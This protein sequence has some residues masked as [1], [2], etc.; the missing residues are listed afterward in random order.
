MSELFIILITTIS[1][2]ASVN[3]I[4]LA[5]VNI[6][7]FQAADTVNAVVETASNS[8]FQLPTLPFT[9]MPVNVPAG[10]EIV[11][12]SDWLGW[13]SI[14]DAAKF[15]F[16]PMGTR[17]YLATMPV[18]IRVV[19]GVLAFD[20][21][22]AVFDV[23]FIRGVWSN[24]IAVRPDSK[25]IDI[26]KLPKEYDVDKIKNFYSSHPRI[27]AARGTEILTSFK[28]FLLGLFSD[29]RSGKS[30]EN[31]RLRAVQFVEII[32]TLGPAFIKVGQALSI[33]PDL[34]SPGKW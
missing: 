12:D 9:N 5:S 3:K 18:L 29:Y 4:V 1:V 2:L 21:I 16:L 14:L 7:P 31:E 13:F 25:D 20:V 17:E 26:S 27:V 10:A 15:P 28:D 8:W 24:L 30:Q 33:R 34:L 23:I 19:F 11:T 22:P 6:D 32:S